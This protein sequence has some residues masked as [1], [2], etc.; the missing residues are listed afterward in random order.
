MKKICVIGLGYRGLPTVALLA[1]RGY[2]VHRV[3]KH[4]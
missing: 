1:N 4:G 2:G 3:K